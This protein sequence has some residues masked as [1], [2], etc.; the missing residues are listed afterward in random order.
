[1]EDI[2][3]SIA[4]AGWGINAKHNGELGFVRCGWRYVWTRSR[5]VMK[6]CELPASADFEGAG[7]DAVVVIRTRGTWRSSQACERHVCRLGTTLLS[8]YDLHCCREAWSTWTFLQDLICKL[9]EL[10]RHCRVTIVLNNITLLC[11]CRE[12]ADRIAAAEDDAL[13]NHLLHPLF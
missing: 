4:S 11:Y 7:C 5:I 13:F 12:V 9:S 6:R 10:H 2:T 8:L 1:M 3:G